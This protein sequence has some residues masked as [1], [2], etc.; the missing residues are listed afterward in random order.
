MFFC[1]HRQELLIPH[2]VVWF[3]IVDLAAAVLQTLTGG[4]VVT[5]LA[6]TVLQTLTGGEVVTVFAAAVLQTLTRT[7]VTTLPN[8]GV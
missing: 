7:S 3:T 5:D 4:E 1:F 8:L 6:K 2:F